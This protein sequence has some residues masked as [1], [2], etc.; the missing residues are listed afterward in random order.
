MEILNQ[1]I[2][3]AF[4]DGKHTKDE[5]LLLFQFAES[6]HIPESTVSELLVKKIR[7]LNFYPSLA[8]G[9]SQKN[10]KTIIC[11]TDWHHKPYE[12]VK[13]GNQVWMKR[14]LNVIHFC[15]GDLIPEAKT[16]EEWKKA[17]EEGKPAWCYY[18][19]NPENGKIYG[20]LYNWFAVNDSRGIAPVGWHLPSDDEWTE[21]IDFLGGKE[22]AG[23]KLKSKTGWKYSGNGTD[24]AEFSALPG[25]YRHDDGSFNQIGFVGSWCYST[26][27]PSW[28]SRTRS[29]HGRDANISWAIEKKE[30]GFSVPCLR[31]IKI[32]RSEVTVEK[33]DQHPFNPKILTAKLKQVIYESYLNFNPTNHLTNGN[34]EN[35]LKE[36]KSVVEERMVWVDVPLGVTVARVEEVIKKYPNAC[37][38][39]DLSDKVILE[40]QEIILFDELKTAP[41]NQIAIIGANLIKSSSFTEDN[42]NQAVD[43]YLEMK[44]DQQK[45]INLKTGEL[46]LFNG[47]PQFQ[48]FGFSRTLREDEDHRTEIINNSS[49]VVTPN[50]EMQCITIGSQ[51][52]MKR[53]LDVSHFR[54]GEQIPEVKTNE[55]WNRAGEE[56]K[57]AWC[58]HNNDPENG[59]IYCKLYNWHAVNDPRGL[60]PEGWHVPSDYEWVELVRFLGGDEIAGKKMKSLTRWDPSESG[61]NEFKFSA[62]P[63]GWR[64]TFGSFGDIGTY[65]DF[66]SSTES[67]S[68]N[69]WTR[70]LY[71]DNA[72]INRSNIDKGFGFSVRCVKSLFEEIKAFE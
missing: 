70:R 38:C 15:N 48:R 52:W 30:L 35:N 44:N 20:K 13:I 54:N 29:L 3:L 34:E 55:E 2:E 19:N 41:I 62:F 25:G 12:S 50:V 24:E 6:L 22:I 61:N 68:P 65:A 56:G 57:P 4:S 45:V 63:G 72:F 42:R 58:N 36:H 69:A 49:V 8:I 47:N 14:N 32:L 5:A 53:N 16:D 17:G 64:S 9:K 7:I 18:D 40:N 33:V 1:Q 11:A 71:H 10:H 67:S 26:D 27:K 28:G 43:A 23:E 59:M 51:V 60:A 31:Y 21:L 37:I 66:W 46:V 39:K